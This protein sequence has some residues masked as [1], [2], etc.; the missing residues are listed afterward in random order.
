MLRLATQATPDSVG[1][2]EHQGEI[3]VGRGRDIPDME[4]LKYKRRNMVGRL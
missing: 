3:C 1:L 2:R 4:Y